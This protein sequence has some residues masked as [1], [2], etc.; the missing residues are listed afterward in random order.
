MAMITGRGGGWKP[1]G[2]TAVEDEPQICASQDQE[3]H[4]AAV[5]KGVVASVCSLPEQL[6]RGAPVTS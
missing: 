5:P 3:G 4:E 6:A 2:G 1:P